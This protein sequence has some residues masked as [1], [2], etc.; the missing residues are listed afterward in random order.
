MSSSPELPS[1]LMQTVPWNEEEEAILI[2]S[3]LILRRNLANYNFPSKLSTSEKEQ[4]LQ[5]LQNAL[6]GIE[7]LAFYKQQDLSAADWDLLY[8]HFLFLRGFEGPPDG[9]GMAINE[10]GEFLALFN[11][12][13]HLEMRALNRTSNWDATWQTLASIEDQIDK[14]KGFAFSPK[15]GYLTSEPTQCGTGLTIYIYLHLPALIQTGQLESALAGNEEV[16]FMGLSG[17]LMELIGDIVIVQNSFSIGM[18]EDAILHALQTTATK[19]I[20]AE[21]TLRSHLKEE[22][23]SEIKDLISKAFGLLVHAYQLETKEALD[24]LSLMK[25]GLSLGEISK[26]SDQKLSEL[27][28]KCRRGHLLHLFPELKEPEEIAKKRAEFLQKELAGICLT[29]EAS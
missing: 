28:F 5:N 29:S 4:V 24:L 13:N 8:E 1:S 7:N 2:G 21:K 23:N 15:F 22:A 10:K 20:G 19:L 26:V 11:M 14:T 25:L 3:S 9:S 18:S 6:Q 27:F 16:N 12:S 17:D